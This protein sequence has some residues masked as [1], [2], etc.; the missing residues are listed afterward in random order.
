MATIAKNN[1]VR[2][3]APKS[4][5]ESAKTVLGLTNDWNQGDILVLDTGVL[6]AAA[7]HADIDN[8]LGIAKQTVVDGKVKSP[9]QGTAVDAAQAIEDLAGPVF[10]VVA[11]LKLKAGDAFAPADKVYLT[12]VD[13]QTVTSVDPG[14]GKHCGIYQGKTIASAGATDEGDVLIGA[15]YSL[16][17]LAI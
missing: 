6:K 4:M 1:I 13:A 11:K 9:Y 3:V 12:A 8:L 5:F 16:G 14:D 7:G 15:R 17:A 2:S 10:G